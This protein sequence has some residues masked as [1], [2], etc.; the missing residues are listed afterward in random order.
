MGIS[1]KKLLL[2]TSLSLMMCICGNRYNAYAI[3]KSQAIPTKSYD[4]ISKGDY[5]SSSYTNG[6]RLYTNY[7]FLGNQNRC[8]LYGTSYN[9]SAGYYLGIINY[10][11]GYTYLNYRGA[12]TTTYS[13]WVDSN[14]PKPIGSK[15]YCGFNMTANSSSASNAFGVGSF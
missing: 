12:G 4:L 6:Y 7:F 10:D 13:I 11:T 15:Y 8:H 9:A 1:I 14:N 3:L 2:A 5:K